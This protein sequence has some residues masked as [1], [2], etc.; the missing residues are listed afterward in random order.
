MY[1]GHCLLSVPSHAQEQKDR[2]R[3]AAGGRNEQRDREHELMCMTLCRSVAL[4]CWAFG[5]VWLEA[6]G[7]DYFTR[8]SVFMLDAAPRERG[9][10]RSIT[11]LPLFSPEGCASLQC[12][13]DTMASCI[14]AR[15]STITLHVARQMLASSAMHDIVRHEGHTSSFIALACLNADLR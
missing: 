5:R 1:L 6:D 9:S 12:G 4:R 14:T 13:H 3:Q 2:L 15:T 10:N 8:N 7:I 11:T